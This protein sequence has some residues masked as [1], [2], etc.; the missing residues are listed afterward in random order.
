MRG[1]AREYHTSGTC[2]ASSGRTRD[3]RRLEEAAA[4]LRVGGAWA[5]WL[6]EWIRW[7]QVH[8]RP[9]SSCRGGRGQDIF[10][11]WSHAVPPGIPMNSTTRAYP[12][13]RRVHAHT[14]GASPRQPIGPMPST[15]LGIGLWS[16][17]ARHRRWSGDWIYGRI[18]RD[19][20]EKTSARS[21]Q[22]TT[23]NRYCNIGSTTASRPRACR[24]DCALFRGPR[25][26]FGRWRSPRRRMT[27][28]WV[29]TLSAPRDTPSARPFLSVSA[30]FCSLE[31]VSYNAF[32]LLQR[33][34]HRHAERRKAQRS[35]EK[36]LT[37][38]IYGNWVLEIDRD[39]LTLRR[40]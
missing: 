25:S 23:S 29:T 4:T 12:S 35:N 40:G 39:I 27:A 16:F 6:G 21:L 13:R 38:V 20:E 11:I 22:V 18:P 14:L 31:T 19:N 32:R 3:Q 9:F 28:S 5:G 37:A 8:C 2:S 26:L 34:S 1:A 33:G 24:M 36:R 10:I 15:R 17:Y 30:R 7:I